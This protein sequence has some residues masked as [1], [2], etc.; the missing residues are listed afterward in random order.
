MTVTGPIVA[1]GGA[2]R[3]IAA[4]IRKETYQLLR[5]PSSIAIGIVMPLLMLVL[6]GYGLNLDVKNVPV[7]LVM[8]DTSADARGVASGFELSEY[9]NT[10][11]V[12]TMAEAERL[13][14]AR[15][16]DGIVRVPFDFARRVE[17]GSAEIQVIVHGADA[18]TR[19]RSASRTGCGST[20]PTRAPTSW[21]RD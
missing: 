20:R 1:R 3:R 16:V 9:F 6:F 4:L 18:N 12:K 5:D 17:L 8:E 15:T 10:V 14:R 21:C 2:L 11:T 7:A 19:L 13:L